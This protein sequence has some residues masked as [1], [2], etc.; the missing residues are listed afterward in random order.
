MENLIKKIRAEQEK[1]G[2]LFYNTSGSKQAYQLGV[3]H[4][5]DTEFSGFSLRLP[6]GNLRIIQNFLLVD[7]EKKEILSISKGE[8][9]HLITLE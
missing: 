7:F 3:K 2:H 4:I 6:D 5:S 9:V 1:G 8:K